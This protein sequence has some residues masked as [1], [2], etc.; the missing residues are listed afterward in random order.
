MKHFV[1]I[2]LVFVAVPVQATYYEIA[3]GYDPGLTLQNSDSL[4]MTGGGIGGL[5][6]EGTSF[7]LIEG[8]S[9]L[10]QGFGG[11]WEISLGSYANLNFLGGEVHELDLNTYATATLSG[12]RIDNIFS[13]QSAYTHAGWPNPHIEVVCDVDSISHNIATNILTGNWLDGTGFEIQLVDVDGY[14]PVF[15][16]IQFIPEPGALLLMGVGGLLLRRKRK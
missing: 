11:I 12:G 15:E 4:L 1:L 9:M 3:G 7:A 13:Y 8:T 10:E 16:N 14:S 6:L 5:Y 2:V